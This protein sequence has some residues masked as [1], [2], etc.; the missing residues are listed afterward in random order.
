MRT[1]PGPVIDTAR[2]LDGIGLLFG[3]RVLFP[4][5][6]PAKLAAKLRDLV[7]HAGW[8]AKGGGFV[9]P[10]QAL[11]IASAGARV[12]LD[13]AAAL[14][15][16][17]DLAA[18]EHQLGGPLEQPA[19]QREALRAKWSPQALAPVPFLM[20]MS[21][22]IGAIAGAGVDQEHKESVFALGLKE[23]NEVFSLAEKDGKPFFDHVEVAASIA[24]FELTVRATPSAA[25]TVPPTGNWVG[26]TALLF[27]GARV[28]V[29]GNVAWMN[30]LSFPQH[31]LMLAQH[32]T[33]FARLV[34]LPEIFAEAPRDISM[35]MHEAGPP[36]EVAR[37]FERIGESWT[38]SDQEIWYGV[39]PY[40]T[41]AA[42]A[43]CSL[44]TDKCAGATKLPI[45]KTTKAGHGFAKVVELDK[46]WVLLLA[47]DAA[48]LDVK[49]TIATVSPLHFEAD[50]KDLGAT[51]D[52][53][54]ALPTRVLGDVSHTGGAIVFRMSASGAP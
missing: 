22:T 41:T 36:E 53:S 5:S 32:G 17:A 51:L 34:G 38:T 26:S 24:P 54:A 6:D 9:V 47:K 44:A 31:P 7:T 11:G 39:L 3:F 2:R 48:A 16:D 13:I 14:G 35:T 23:A 30:A 52:A 28:E 12:A 21:Q 37:R 40:Q 19:A 10:H 4:A 50:T 1:A 20:G 27:P 43:Q 25:T 42:Q 46:R 49:P 18:L 33:T 29:S 15:I 8:K 45:G